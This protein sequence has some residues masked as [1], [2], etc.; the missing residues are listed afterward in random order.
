MKFIQVA[1]RQESSY[2]HLQ[3]QELEVLRDGILEVHWIEYCR[4]CGQF[5][6]IG[7]FG[8]NGSRSVYLLVATYQ[9]AILLVIFMYS[10]L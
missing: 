8:G 7:N 4:L 3:C 2:P 6:L 1:K 10:V 5:H 9:G